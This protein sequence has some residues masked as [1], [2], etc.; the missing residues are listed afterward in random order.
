MNFWDSSAIV[1]FVLD[2]P[3]SIRLYEIFNKDTDLAVWWGSEVEF[4]SAVARKTREKRLTH[5]Q[6]IAL[7]RRLEQFWQGAHEAP[8]L[9]RTRKL[10]ARL[11]R[12]HP[13]KAADAFQLAAALMVAEDTPENL[14]FVCLD[15]QLGE[16]A[17]REGLQWLPD[18]YAGIA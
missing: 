16:A 4:H 6:A 1:A 9:E 17:M 8:P 13:L 5:S 10:A 11:V 12:V 15:R 14:G 2:E 3:L 7:Q 18:P